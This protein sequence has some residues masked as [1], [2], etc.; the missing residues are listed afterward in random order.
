[1]NTCTLL[2]GTLN[3]RF[4]F[5]ANKCGQFRACLF[6][7][8]F[9]TL[10][11]I[12]VVLFLRFRQVGVISHLRV[13]VLESELNPSVY[14][15]DYSRARCDHGRRISRAFVKFGYKQAVGGKARGLNLSPARSLKR[16]ISRYRA[17][18]GSEWRVIIS[19]RQTRR[20]CNQTRI[21]SAPPVFVNGGRAGD[22]RKRKEKTAKKMKRKEEKKTKIPPNTSF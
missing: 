9:A 19:G 10:K 12:I 22:G 5:Y 1:M 20:R 3:S 7:R 17:L 6:I 15:D 8:G 13:S 2:F 14:F 18:N 21:K 4:M 16:Y 11:Y